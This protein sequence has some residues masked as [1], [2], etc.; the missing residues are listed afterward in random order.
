M[1]RPFYK[2][3]HFEMEPWYEL[4]DLI[5]TP[6]PKKKTKRKTQNKEKTTPDLLYRY[7]SIQY[8]KY[9]SKCHMVCKIK[10]LCI[11]VSKESFAH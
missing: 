6:P 4:Y 11:Y 3:V 10:L 8:C 1:L 2:K 7:V 5:Y 9:T